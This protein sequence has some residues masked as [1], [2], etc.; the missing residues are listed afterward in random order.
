MKKLIQHVS[1][2]SLLLIPVFIFAA[3]IWLRA[4]SGMPD[5]KY[6]A[7]VSFQVPALKSVFETVFFSFITK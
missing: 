4:G 7:S 5:E 6:R 2:F 3:V 1:P